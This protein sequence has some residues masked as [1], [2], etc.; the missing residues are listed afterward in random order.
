MIIHLVNA[1]GATIAILVM[2]ALAFGGPM[3]DLH[4]RLPMCRT[5]YPA[6]NGAPAVPG[7]QDATAPR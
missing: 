5:R 6:R 1:L 3:V 4:D 7:A 2:A